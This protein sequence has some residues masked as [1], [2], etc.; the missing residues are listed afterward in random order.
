MLHGVINFHHADG[1]RER[2]G[3]HDKDEGVGG[4][5]A[6]TDFAP[7]IGGK[8]DVFPINPDV[9]VLGSQRLVNLRDKLSI[10]AR[11]GNENIRHKTSLMR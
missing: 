2:V 8:G 9:A 5:D 4:F 10:L 6:R 11:L 7:P 3:R 1:R